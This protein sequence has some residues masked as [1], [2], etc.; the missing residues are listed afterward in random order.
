ML[1]ALRPTLFDVV[2]HEAISFLTSDLGGGLTPRGVPSDL[3]GGE[4]GDV[5]DD[6]RTATADPKRLLADR[7]VFASWSL[8]AGSD[9]DPEVAVL[10]LFQRLITLHSNDVTHAEALANVDIERC[11][12]G[13]AMTTGDE[14]ATLFRQRMADI[15]LRMSSTAPHGAAR[16][17]YLW[18]QSLSDDGQLVEAHKVASAV[19]EPMNPVDG[20]PGLCTP[21]H[22]EHTHT[23]TRT[24]ARVHTHVCFHTV[25]LHFR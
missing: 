5:E 24:H 23:H 20:D 8:S 14:A 2:A 15:A 7:R 17:R 21:L 6:M 13:Q 3:V 12:H 25:L 9:V 4:G 1:L 11:T 22:H 19:G 16:A 10:V 18:A